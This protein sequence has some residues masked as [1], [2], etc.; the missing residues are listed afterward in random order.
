MNN[1]RFAEFFDKIMDKNIEDVIVSKKDDGY[2]LFGRFYISE[3]KPNTYEVIDVSYNEVVEFS[4]LRHAMA[5]ASLI[6][7]K[8]FHLARRLA[9]LELKMHSLNLDLQAIKNLYRTHENKE[10]YWLKFHDTTYNRK[11]IQHEIN[12]IIHIAKAKQNH[13]FSA[14]ARDKNFRYWG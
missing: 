3:R 5:W 13:K 4:T 8:Q 7:C 2:V 6:N 10:I 12:E 9:K 11:I 1:K 14:D